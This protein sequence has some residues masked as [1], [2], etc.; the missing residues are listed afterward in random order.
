MIITFIL[1][2]LILLIFDMMALRWGYDSR[3]GIDSEEWERRQRASLSDANF[4]SSRPVTGKTVHAT[5]SRQTRIHGK[6]QS[7]SPGLYSL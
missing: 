5:D 1:I 7:L 2:V 4:H 3:D 6:A